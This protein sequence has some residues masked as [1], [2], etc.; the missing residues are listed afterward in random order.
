[1]YEKDASKDVG[2][3]TTNTTE[4]A[5]GTAP[6][7]RFRLFYFILLTFISVCASIYLLYTLI[8]KKFFKIHFYVFVGHLAVLY[9]IFGVY[10]IPLYIIMFETNGVWPLGQAACV[11]WQVI[12]NLCTYEMEVMVVVIGM[13]RLWAIFWPIHYKQRRNHKNLAVSLLISWMY[14]GFTVLPTLIHDRLTNSYSLTVCDVSIKDNYPYWRATISMGF[15][16]PAVSAITLY[17]II[18]CKIVRDILAKRRAVSDV[19]GGLRPPITAAVSEEGNV[20]GKRPSGHASADGARDARETEGKRQDKVKILREKRVLLVLLVVSCNYLICLLPY[21]VYCGL[22]FYN[23]VT[24][25]TMAFTVCHMLMYTHPALDA[26]A[27]I[28]TNA[29]IRPQIFHATSG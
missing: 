16:V 4:D 6:F 17:F 24:P 13:D 26:L 10:I 11:A 9:I 5:F 25:N 3:A 29:E 19:E 12:S 18:A 21:A 20:R 2:Y 22:W 14:S 8:A 28:M 7:R 15:L 27:F 1:M 23:L